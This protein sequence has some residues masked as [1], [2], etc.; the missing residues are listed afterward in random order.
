MLTMPHSKMSA[1][2]Q[3]A[4]QMRRRSS[5][6]VAPTAGGICSHSKADVAAA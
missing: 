2:L 4:A 5:S 3:A 6:G 1:A